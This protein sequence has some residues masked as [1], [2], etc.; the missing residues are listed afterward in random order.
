MKEVKDGTNGKIDYV[1]ELEQS[2]VQITI[3]SQAIYRFNQTEFNQIYRFYQITNGI[4]HRTRK[5]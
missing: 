4:S 5:F 3:L 1:L 2:I